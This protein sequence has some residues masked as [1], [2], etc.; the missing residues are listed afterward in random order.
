MLKQLKDVDTTEAKSTV[1]TT[2]SLPISPLSEDDLVHNLYAQ[3]AGGDIPGENGDDLDVPQSTK[4][5]RKLLHTLS[6]L[7]TF[8]TSPSSCSL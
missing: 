6:T 2:S 3:L 1:G 5:I 8:P 4:M 7:G